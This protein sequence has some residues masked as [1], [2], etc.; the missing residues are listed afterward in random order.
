MAYFA[1]STHSTWI[2]SQTEVDSKRASRIKKLD[3]KVKKM[4]KDKL[5]PL[6]E[7]ANA[8]RALIFEG[9]K[10]ARK[11]ILNPEEETLFV[12]LCC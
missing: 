2:F 9:I 1:N 7:N 12:N 10:K 5:D 3:G 4:G 11:S 6:P 8:E